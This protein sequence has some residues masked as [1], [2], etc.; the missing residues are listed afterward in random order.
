VVQANIIIA[1]D[2]LTPRMCVSPGILHV[3]VHMKGN[4]QLLLFSN[5]LSMTPGTLSIQFNE[6]KTLLEVHVLYS[7]NPEKVLQEIEQL[8][9]KIMVISGN[10]G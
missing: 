2:I 9:K 7:D 8:E 3:P 6:Q 1:Y 4:V 5:L 10:N